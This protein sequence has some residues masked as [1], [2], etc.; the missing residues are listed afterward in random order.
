LKKVAF[1]TVTSLTWASRLSPYRQ[2]SNSRAAF[3][4]IITLI[5]FIGSWLAM[6]GLLFISP[7]LSALSCLVA[8]GFVVRIFM[9]QH[10]CGHNSLFASR[11][12]NDWVGRCLGVLT[13]TPY[14]YW[15][16][17]HAMHHAGSGN[18]DRRGMG[19][20]NT[21]TVKE[22]EALG[23]WGRLGYRLYR[24]PLVMFGI[25]PIYM[26]LFNQRM[27]PDCFRQGRTSWLGVMLTNVAIF[28]LA[29][30]VM[31]FVGWKAFLI[32]HLPIVIVGAA[33]GVWLFY[34]QHQFDE[35][36]WERNPDWDHETAALNGSSYYDLPKPLMWMTGNIGIH[37]LHHL[38]SRIPFYRL[39]QV[40][41][42]FPE[43]QNVTRFTIWQSF[44]C[45][46]LTLWDEASKRLVTFREARQMMP[47]KLVAAE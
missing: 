28:S 37:H 25:G 15:K 27:P 39:P 26:F 46:R 5:A 13:L 30:L 38:S 33:M 23:F 45:V 20:I 36:H 40:L 31:Y 24:H 2:A 19:D 9:L 17:S 43:L 18:L 16:H 7:W 32:V 22:Y 1:L 29:A 4:L 21:L 11:K 10:D 44:K 3:E 14:D 35:T 8:A 34:V 41:R 12:L 6:Y 47:L 42:D